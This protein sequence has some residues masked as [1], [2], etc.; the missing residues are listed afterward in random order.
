MKLASLRVLDLAER[1][2]RV[3]KLTTAVVRNCK[4]R[5]S[6]DSDCYVLATQQDDSNKLLNVSNDVGSIGMF[7]HN[8]GKRQLKCNGESLLPYLIPFFPLVP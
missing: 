4:Q 2:R 3:C 8:T 1:Q 7:C 5:S 6:T